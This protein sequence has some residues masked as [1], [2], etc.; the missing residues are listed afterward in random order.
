VTA[1]LA[2]L[3]DA[4]LSADA[5]ARPRQRQSN[6]SDRSEPDTDQHENDNDAPAWSHHS[7]VDQALL[8]PML[9]HYVEL[10][11]EHPSPRRRALLHR[12]DQPRQSVALCDQLETTSTKGA[13]LKRG[14]TLVLTPETVLEEGMLAALRNN[15]LAAIV[16]EPATARHPLRWGLAN[17]DVSTDDVLVMANPPGAPSAC[18]SVRWHA[19]P[20]VHP[21]PNRP[22]K[23]ITAWRAW[24]DW[25]CRSSPWPYV[26]SAD[27]S[28]TSM[29]PNTSTRR[30]ASH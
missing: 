4:S 22:S 19:P 26:P 30:R 6:T 24:M 3:S 13:L 9:R 1:E 23:L 18:G 15:W 27:C 10:K 28:T 25:V 16:V 8:T 29:T 2:D 14:I 17:A 20:S 12:T 7:E 21:R 5:A 11:A